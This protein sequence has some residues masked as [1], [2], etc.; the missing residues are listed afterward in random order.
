MN[1]WKVEEMGIKAKLKEVRGMSREETIYLR[2]AGNLRIP[3]HFCTSLLTDQHNPTICIESSYHFMRIKRMRF[4]NPVAP[5]IANNTTSS[6][7]YLAL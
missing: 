1:E 5:S 2:A 3:D 7:S 4:G 6:F